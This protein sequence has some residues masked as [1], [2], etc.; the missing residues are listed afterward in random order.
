MI[1]GISPRELDVVNATMEPG[2]SP[3][4]GGALLRVNSYMPM[5]IVVVRELDGGICACGMDTRTPRS[6]VRKWQSHGQE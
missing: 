3:C 4:F 6:L 2:C 5:I 1:S